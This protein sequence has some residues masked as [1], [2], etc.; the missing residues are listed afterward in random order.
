MA[1]NVIRKA[2]T[3]MHEVSCKEI[4]DEHAYIYSHVAVYF[5]PSS[6]MNPESTLNEVVP[7]YFKDVYSDERSFM[8]KF[9]FMWTRD[10]SCAPEQLKSQK[11]TNDG[12]VALYM[13]FYDQPY[14]FMDDDVKE[15]KFD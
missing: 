11:Y 12:G 7:Q 3:D 15:R 13:K 6:S 2:I 14:V 10:R 5:A 1:V 4:L 9:M 8:R